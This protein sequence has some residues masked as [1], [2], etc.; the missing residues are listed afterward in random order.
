MNLVDCSPGFPYSSRERVRYDYWGGFGDG[1]SR[2]FNMKEHSVVSEVLSHLLPYKAKKN[3]MGNLK[4]LKSIG[5]DL[6][7]AAHISIVTASHINGFCG[8][9]GWEFLVEVV[10]CRQVS[11]L[12]RIDEHFE[13]PVPRS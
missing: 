4:S 9:E 5:N 8:I 13:D 1:K 6:E 12:D 2:I 7:V 10:L 3:S 11:S